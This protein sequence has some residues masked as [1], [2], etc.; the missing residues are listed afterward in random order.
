M[1]TNKATESYVHFHSLVDC[2]LADVLAVSV[3]QLLDDL[4]GQPTQATAEIV[5]ASAP[6][7]A[8]KQDSE[9]LQTVL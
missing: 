1:R 8:V 7:P 3:V 5:P 2:I 4:A 9:K 6:E